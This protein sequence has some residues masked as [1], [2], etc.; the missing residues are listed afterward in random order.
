MLCV[1]KNAE[2]WQ[3]WFYCEGLKILRCRFDSYPFHET[4]SIPETLVVWLSRYSR[5]VLEVRKTSI[6]G[7][8]LQGDGSERR[9]FLLHTTVTD[10]NSLKQ[11]YTWKTKVKN[12]QKTLIIAMKNCCYLMLALRLKRYYNPNI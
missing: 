11:N 4:G 6:G 5:K 3:R 12:K 1:C 10:N 2:W 9:A 8:T 7:S